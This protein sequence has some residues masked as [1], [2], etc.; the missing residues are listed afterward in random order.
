MMKTETKAATKGEVVGNEKEQFELVTIDEW[1]TR[2]GRCND[3]TEEL[4]E[5]ESVIINNETI[6][7][8]IGPLPLIDLR[9]EE[10]FA[11]KHIL[12]VSGGGCANDHRSH[13]GRRAD[14]ITSHND[15]VAT[16]NL[17]TV[18]NLPLETLLSGERSCE[19]PPRHV[20]F[21]ILIPTLTS[22]LHRP[23]KLDGSGDEVSSLIPTDERM[24]Q[25]QISNLFF[26]TSSKATSQSRKPWK[27]R[28]V[29]QDCE[30]TWIDANKLGLIA[31]YCGGKRNRN[32][33]DVSN[34]AMPLPRLWQPDAM[35]K[36]I[37]LPL[38][39]RRI[40]EI[41]EIFHA[42]NSKT[43]SLIWDLGSGAGRDVCFLAEELKF[44]LHGQ[45]YQSQELKL[46]GIDNHKGSARRCLP[47]WKHHH[48]GQITEARLM[49]LK[50]IKM[51]QDSILRE[52][53]S[54]TAVNVIGNAPSNCIICVYMIRFLNQKVVDYL[55]SETCPLA[56][57]TLFAI[58]H[59][60]KQYEGASW[61]FDHPKESSVL[62]RNELNKKFSNGQWK[63]LHDEIVP[64]GDH[65]RTLQQFIAE[66]L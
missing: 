27:V 5:K 8:S 62:Q 1:W 16:M 13:P 50:N 20:E 23:K 61:D 29:I 17:P 44:Y 2:E 31:K 60:C 66:K 35:I 59:F 54:Q 43:T 14:T 51:L 52:D 55:I 42:K 63:I 56:K 47:L 3:R 32:G 48:V 36:S 38:L 18:V 24:L 65:G 37:L 19:L 7:K 46:V 57:G 39:K 41:D 58:S 64:D 21:A 10:H 34:D 12:S 53:R 22:H 9:P 6:K 49:D 15:D 30:K 11:Q 40:D 25:D 45:R 4:L 26:A 33:D 28:Q